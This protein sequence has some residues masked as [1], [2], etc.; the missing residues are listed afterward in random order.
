MAERADKSQRAWKIAG[1]LCA[2]VIVAITLYRAWPIW[3]FKATSS[4]RE[5]EIISIVKYTSRGFVPAIST[6][7]RSRSA[8]LWSDFPVRHAELRGFRRV[9]AHPRKGLA[10]PSGVLC[11]L[12]TYTLPF[13]CC[14]R[15]WPPASGVPLSSVT[16]DMLYLLIFGKVYAVFTGYRDCYRNTFSS[17]FDSVDEVFSAFEYFLPVQIEALTF[18]LVALLYVAFGRFA[19]RSDRL[20]LAAVAAAILGFLVFCLLQDGS[21]SGCGLHDRAARVPRRS[22][23]VFGALDPHACAR[24]S[25]AA[26]AADC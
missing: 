12:G 20:T 10:Q 25:H 24:S 15:G 9:A 14:V 1:L 21:R 17:H 26:L 8:G 4:L 22:H 16:G 6:Y 2:A 19:A 7:S 18:A 5:D 11:V 13:L 3:H 23:D